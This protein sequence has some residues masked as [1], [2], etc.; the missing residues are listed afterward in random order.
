MD[1]DP[2]EFDWEALR[3]DMME[4]CLNALFAGGISAAVLDEEAI[5]QADP[6]GLRRL[7]RDY[8]IRLERYRL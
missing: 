6:E 3:R 8:G 2:A 5:E 7:A 4:E 1:F